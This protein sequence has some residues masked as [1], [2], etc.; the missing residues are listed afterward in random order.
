MK[1]LDTAFITVIVRRFCEGNDLVL[2]ARQ[3][4]RWVVL[5]HMCIVTHFLSLERL[6]R[7][8]AWQIVLSNEHLVVEVIEYLVG[9]R[10]VGLERWY[11]FYNELGCTDETYKDAE[12]RELALLRRLSQMLVELIVRVRI[13]ANGPYHVRDATI[14]H[15]KFSVRWITILGVSHAVVGASWR[16]M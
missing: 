14:D 13:L 8:A 6:A 10:E 3:R 12:Y 16:H 1:T 15:G 5:V 2:E 11:S 9:E 4:H 7:R